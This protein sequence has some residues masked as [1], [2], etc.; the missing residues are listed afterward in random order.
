MKISYFLLLFLFSLY[1]GYSS[2]P[3]PIASCQTLDTAGV[4]TLTDNI[5]GAICFTIASSD[6]VID[7]DDYTI[8]SNSRSFYF[9]GLSYDN[10]SIIN[11]NIITTGGYGIHF[12]SFGSDYNLFENVTIFNSGI[13]ISVSFVEYSNFNNINIYNGLSGFDIRQGS[14]NNNFSNIYIENITTEGISFVSSDRNNFNSVIINGSLSG[15]GITY[16]TSGDF[17]Y[18][19]DTSLYNLDT[20]LYFYGSGNNV[21]DNSYIDDTVDSPINFT[22]LSFFSANSNNFTNSYLSN[23]SNIFS[24][25]WTK[26][27]STFQDNTYLSGSI[28]N[29]GCFDFPTNGTCENTSLVESL[30]IETTQ[31]NFPLNSYTSL[32][33]LLISVLLYFKK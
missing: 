27:V 33:I 30:S 3:G 29:G 22:S 17:T 31:S 4:Y 19:N 18:F 21:L 24:N 15:T 9:S 16:P 20:G 14:N 26:S 28:I 6:M 8:T 7:C 12:N 1:Q 11:C 2:T 25:D 23:F 10:L 32:L 13:G 5:S